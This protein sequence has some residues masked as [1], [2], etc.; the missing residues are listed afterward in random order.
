[1]TTKIYGIDI[2]YGFTKVVSA[3]QGM[4]VPVSFPSVVGTY[5]RGIQVNGLKASVPDIVTIDS[6]QYYVG[7]AALGHGVRLLTGRHQ[8]WISSPA[9]R[10]LLLHALSINGSGA[11]NLTIVSGL[12]V[13]FFKRDKDILFNL[14]KKATEGLCIACDVH[15]IPQ[16]VG[17]FFDALFNDS[18]HIRVGKLVEAKTGILDIG[19]YTTDLVTISNMEFVERQMESFESGV[20]S[21][22]EGIAR[23]IEEEYG[24]RP[25]LHKTEQAVSNGFIRVFGVEKDVQHIAIRRFTE[26]GQEVEARAK[27]IWKSGADIDMALITGGGAALLKPYL[28]LYR[29]AMVVDNAQLANATGYYKLGRRLTGH[30]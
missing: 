4:I 21:A 19:Y 6:R 10:A 14:I 24:I 30:V 25:D 11:V 8:D 2:G 27:T 26:L 15:I 16:P 17:S 12:P 28:N 9:Y 23:D 1:M 7:K 5:E 22:L 29:H 18:G 3:S 13:N 20:S